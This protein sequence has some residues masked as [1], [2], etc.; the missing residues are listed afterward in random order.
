MRQYRNLKLG[1][2]IASPIMTYNTENIA[3][4]TIDTFHIQGKLRE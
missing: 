4:F 3:D 1:Y 2:G